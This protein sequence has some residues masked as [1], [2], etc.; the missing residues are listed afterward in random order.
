MPSTILRPCKSPK[1]SI[2]PS[3]A[4]YVGDMTI[5]VETGNN[6]GIKTVAV[7]TG[8][9]TKDE[10]SEL[11]PYRIIDGVLDVVGIVEEL[12]ACNETLK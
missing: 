9:N 12:N 4:L 7:T 1:F 8:S 10:I 2:L 11:K 5:D 3:Q 6:A